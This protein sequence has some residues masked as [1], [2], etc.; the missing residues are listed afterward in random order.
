MNTSPSEV[1]VAA[2]MVQCDVMVKSTAL[3][4]T[5]GLNPAQ[6][7]PSCVV[8]SKFPTSLY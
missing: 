2:W 5:A 1:T 8:L 6:P 7:L 4:Q 3:S